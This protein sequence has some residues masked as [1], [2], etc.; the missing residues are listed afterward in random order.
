MKLKEYL[1]DYGI[2]YLAFAEKV[3]LNPKTLRDIIN[4]ADMKLSTAIKIEDAT[5]GEVTCRDLANNI[6]KGEKDKGQE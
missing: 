1:D 4:G 2:K 6:K 3:K 5:K